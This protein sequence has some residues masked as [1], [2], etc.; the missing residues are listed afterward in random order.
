[1]GTIKYESFKFRTVSGGDTLIGVVILP[2][3]VMN[4]EKSI[5]LFTIDKDDMKYD[6][7][8]GLDSVINFKLCLDENLVLSQKKNPETNEI[9]NKKKNYNDEIFINW[10]EFIPINEFN[11]KTDHLDSNKKKAIYDLVDKYSGSFAKNKYDIGKVSKYEAQIKL[12]E[13]C[14]VSKKPYRCSFDD[15]LEIE[16]QVRE[17]LKNGLIEQSMSPFASPVTL[18]YKKEGDVKLKNR[19]CIDFRELNKLVVPE[20]QPFPLIDDLIVRTKGCEW[21]SSFDINSAFW[22]IPIRQKDRFKTGFVTQNGHWQWISMPFGYRNAPA[23]FQRILTGIIRKRGLESFCVNYIDDILVFSKTFQEHLQ[24]I[25][26][27][28]KAIMEEGFRL[29]FIKCDFARDEVRYLGH[30]IGRGT[31]KPLTDSLKALHDFPVPKSRKNVRQFL[32]KVNFYLKFIPNASSLLDPLHNLLRKNVE[33]I[34]SP[35]CDSIFRKVIH[36]LTSSPVLAVFDRDVPIHI[37]TDASL[38]GVGAVLKQ[39]QKDGSEKPVAYFSRKLNNCQKKKKAIYIECIAVREAVRYW[40]YWLMGRKFTVFSDHKPLEN[41][42]IKARTDEELGDLLHYL[43][44]FD[45][46]IIYKPGSSNTEADCLSR[47]PVLGPNEEQLEDNIK[48]VNSVTLEEIKENQTDLGDTSNK[49]NQKIMNNIVYKRVKNKWKI[50]I[51]EEFGKSLVKKIHFKYGHIGVKHVRNLLSPHYTFKNMN[52]SISQ[53]CTGCEI[54]IKNKSRIKNEKIALGHLGPARAPFEI[55]SLDTIGGLGGKRSTK[56]YLHLLVDHFSRYAYILTSAGQSASDFIKLIKKINNENQINLLLTDQYGGM[57]SNEFEEF[58]QEENI[59]HI[60]TAVDSPESN[61]LNERLN[62][63]LVNRIRCRTNE[64][65][66]NKKKAWTIVAQRCVNEYNDSYH[67]VTGFS[68]SYLLY[69]KIPD[70]VPIEIREQNDFEKDRKTAFINSLRDHDRNKKRLNIE[71][72]IIHE[73]RIGDL[74]FVENGNKL[75]REKLDEIRIGPLE[76]INIRSNSVFE[77]KVNNNKT[78]NTRLYHRNKLI[79]FSRVTDN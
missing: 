48:L 15:Q 36:F 78:K 40:Q 2:L 56:K 28:L 13:N 71:N 1:M 66:E 4:I 73:F 16:S 18:A 11:I 33:F 68:P 64:N 29:K 26:E 6:V 10:S 57:C 37:Y 25:E 59:E 51:T 14:Y 38:E 47:N 42:R 3:K 30:V 43:L 46:D 41:L 21:F 44:Q 24:H 19:M 72:K 8:L 60:I 76:I 70:T 23:I 35:L 65:S 50:L 20:S 75:N 5:R 69:G 49:H 79:P 12:S 34:W 53:I 61:G 58:L 7:I 63:T 45:F 27:L 67:T 52:Q 9:L 39:P 74:V 31:V 77:I 55:M 32:G 54:C 22:T 17:L 62:Q